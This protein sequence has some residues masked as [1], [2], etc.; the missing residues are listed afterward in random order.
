MVPVAVESQ[1]YLSTINTA[2]DYCVVEMDALLI[3]MM[4]SPIFCRHNKGNV[5]MCF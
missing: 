2:A 3:Y 1:N 5:I 4:T